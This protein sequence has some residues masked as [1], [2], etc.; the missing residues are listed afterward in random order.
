[1]TKSTGSSNKTLI[2]MLLIAAGCIVAAAV[3]FFYTARFAIQDEAF[4]RLLSEQSVYSQSLAKDGGLAVRGSNQAFTF[5]QTGREQFDRNL[6]E[7]MEGGGMTARVSGQVRD[8]VTLMQ[9]RWSGEGRDAVSRIL[10]AKDAFGVAHQGLATVNAQMPEFAQRMDDVINRLAGINGVDRTWLYHLGRQGSFAQRMQRD[11]NTVVMGGTDVTAAANRIEG[12]LAYV[13][14]IMR[15]MFDGDPQLGLQPLVN[16]AA[17]EEIRTANVVFNRVRDAVT[18]VE[19]MAPSLV[20]AHTAL[21]TL[22]TL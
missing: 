22:E 12:D 2:V 3:N 20:D 6:R 21:G 16:T 5:L 9:Q 1:M 15:A 18:T 17:G 11:V 4:L 14:Q 8:E 19:S 7:L 13:S 10:A